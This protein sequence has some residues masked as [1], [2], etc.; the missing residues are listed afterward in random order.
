[1]SMQVL[2]DIAG[3]D[4]GWAAQRA[5]M[6]IAITE[7]LSAGNISPDEARELM[8]D[9]VRMDQLD[10]EADDIELKAA[11]V[12]AVYAVSHLI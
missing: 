6:V 10:S 12:S 1:M 5:A 11:L 2:Y 7:Q 8:L 9:L 4:R 3:S